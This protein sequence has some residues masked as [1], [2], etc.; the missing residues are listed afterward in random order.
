M[1][2]AHG[3]EAS[4]FNLKIQFSHKKYSRD[5]VLQQIPK[6]NPRRS[7][8]PKQNATFPWQWK[9]PTLRQRTSRRHYFLAIKS[10]D[11]HVAISRECCD[12]R[13]KGS[14]NEVPA[15][16]LQ[17]GAAQVDASPQTR[18]YTQAL[19]VDKCGSVGQWEKSILFT[20]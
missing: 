10:D 6:R 17:E 5:L 1:S 19:N 16:L 7:F 18:T 15:R 3:L 12:A 11:E 9:E 2:Y 14:S 20:D 4:M 8:S 13:I